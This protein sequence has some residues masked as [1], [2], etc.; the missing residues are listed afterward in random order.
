MLK[1]FRKICTAMLAL[2][3]VSSASMSLPALAEEAKTVCVFDL[4]LTESR[5]GDNLP[6]LADIGGALADSFVVG[7]VSEDISESGKA[8]VAHSVKSEGFEA[9][10]PVKTPI[11]AKNKAEEDMDY[12]FRIKLKTSEQYNSDMQLGPMTLDTVNVTNRVSFIRIINNSL[13]NNN[14]VTAAQG[15]WY[16]LLIRLHVGANDS[17]D[18]IGYSLYG[19]DE[20]VPDS[21]H[22]T[23]RGAAVSGNNHYFTDR[24]AIYV[25]VKGFRQPGCAFADFSV[26]GYNAE[27]YAQYEN[28]ETEVSDIMSS[29]ENGEMTYDEAADA[30]NRMNDIAMT[31]DG[32]LR[33]L[34]TDSF[35][36]VNAG[37]KLAEK[38]KEEIYELYNTEITDDNLDEIY[39]HADRIS[40]D[41]DKILFADIREELNLQISQFI[42]EKLASRYGVF[43]EYDAMDYY[44]AD[45]MKNGGWYIEGA[46]SGGNGICVTGKI[47]K[48][49]KYPIDMNRKCDYTVQM[50][51]VEVKNNGFEG[52]IGGLSYGVCKIGDKYYPFIDDVM[53]STEIK[54]NVKYTYFLKITKSEAGENIAQ[55]RIYGNDKTFV[56]AAEVENVFSSENNSVISVTSDGSVFGA[57]TKEVYPQDYAMDCAELL[58]NAI[59]NTATDD[60]AIADREN[61]LVVAKNKI[62]LLRTGVFADYLQHMYDYVNDIL[63]KDKLDILIEKL[64]S[65]LKEEY[66]NTANALM[67]EMSS[68]VLKKEYY[69]KI[70]PYIDYIEN[71]IPII[72]SVGIAGNIKAGE[73][74]SANISINDPYGKGS[75]SIQ[76][77]LGGTVSGTDKTYHIPNNSADKTLRLKVTAKNSLG[78]EGTSV[79]TDSV[80]IAGGKISIGGNSSGSG[81]GLNKNSFTGSNLN[82]I[83]DT[84][85]SNNVTNSVNANNMQNNISN[86]N[87]ADIKGHWAENEIKT[88]ADMGIIS[89]IDENTFDP[90]RKITRAEFTKIMS[91]AFGLETDSNTENIF[92]D[93]SENAWYY[94][95][96]LAAYAKGIVTGDGDKFMPDNAI[97]RE[98]AAVIITRTYREYFETLEKSDSEIF[99]DYSEISS[100][101]L[102]DIEIALNAGLLYGISDMELA[103]Q[104]P[105]SRAE[106]TVMIYRTLNKLGFM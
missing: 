96:V 5:I 51:D 67:E 76:W 62:T 69:D 2:S 84:V 80:K 45:T 9:Y 7:D 105:V 43:T 24:E 27:A 31:V 65:D 46:V 1:R 83:S 87:F 41:V 3:L 79:F 86:K 81:G 11:T 42:S 26:Y 29:I 38:L 60:N 101:A 39:A 102:E 94:D 63:I 44:D 23:A 58:Y 54:P 103:P 77:L 61:S 72:E 55:L 78:I 52:S 66:I 106:S 17:E 100:W 40:A 30:V 35:K 12:I 22:I 21:W 6:G 13:I 50:Q 14:T 85:L 97:T 59:E 10:F 15:E 104:R 91:S 16:N 34:L 57:I 70:Y 19:I 75:Y 49:L 90:D 37:V 71:M 32:N 89:G 36:S 56:R 73:T 68:A 92:A 74:V 8:A 88:M 47:Q 18:F 98:Q 20:K 53:G 4:D 28:A 48:Q 82:S 64:Q 33:S 99:S 93:V 95:Y 25:G